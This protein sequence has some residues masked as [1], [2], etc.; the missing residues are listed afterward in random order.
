MAYLGDLYV[1]RV[2]RSKRIGALGGVALSAMGLAGIIGKFVYEG[3]GRLYNGSL[4]AV[5]ASAAALV[6]CAP[7]GETM[8]RLS[9]CTPRGVFSTRLPG[10]TSSYLSP[11]R[12]GAPSCASLR[13]RCRPRRGARAPRSTAYSLPCLS[14]PWARRACRSCPRRC[15]PVPPRARCSRPPAWPTAAAGGTE[16]YLRHALL[17]RGHGGAP[18]RLHVPR[19]RRHTRVILKRMARLSK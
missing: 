8:G 10:A 12:T 19:L 3:T 18:R 17:S 11:R 7:T 16:H 5:G 4:V 2:E 6:G 14:T 13:Q 9:R 15:V 1:D